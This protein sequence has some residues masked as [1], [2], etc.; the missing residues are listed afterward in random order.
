MRWLRLIAG[1]CLLALGVLGLFLPV[2]QGWLLIGLGA[3][4]LAREVPLFRRLSHWVEDRYPRLGGPLRK[5]RR[6]MGV[7]DEESGDGG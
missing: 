2:L 5:F 7:A 1:S 6:K 4:L 3:I